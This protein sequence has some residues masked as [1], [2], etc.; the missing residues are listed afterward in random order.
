M[1]QAFKSSLS[2]FQSF[3]ISGNDTIYPIQKQKRGEGK[4]VPHFIPTEQLSWSLCT[5]MS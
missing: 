5:V 4:F 1:T 2:L 3:S